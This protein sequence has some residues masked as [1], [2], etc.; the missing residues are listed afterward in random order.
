MPVLPLAKGELEGVVLRATKQP[1]NKI[2]NI[3]QGMMKAEGQRKK[4]LP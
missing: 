4:N 3:E 2:S 1:S